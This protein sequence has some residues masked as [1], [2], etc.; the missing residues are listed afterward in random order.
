MHLDQVLG[1][2]ASA[3]I[4]R[5]TLNQIKTAQILI[6]ASFVN[7][8]HSNYRNVACP[9]SGRTRVQNLFGTYARFILAV[10]I[11]SA[12]GSRT[13]N[14]MPRVEGKRIFPLAKVCKIAQ[15]F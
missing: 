3:S 12:Y 1:V 2:S 11:S 13:Q 15:S 14:K 9:L 4:E 8:H 5:C 6:W 7:L 10:K